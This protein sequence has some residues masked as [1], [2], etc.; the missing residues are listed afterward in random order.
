MT[1]LGERIK[2]LRVKNGLTQ[3]E[4]AAKMG[5]K[6]KSTINKIELGVND[7]PQSRVAQFAKVLNT[8]VG[9]LMGW[10]EKP[11]DAGAL[12]AEVLKDPALTSL[13]EDFLTL[14]DSDRAT[15]R[16]LVASLA[17]KKKD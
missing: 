1:K 6:S 5:Y 12:A 8:S 10:E 9:Y 4:L 14:D 17:K 3:E 11:E 13:V 2:Q 7:I 16:A 15:V